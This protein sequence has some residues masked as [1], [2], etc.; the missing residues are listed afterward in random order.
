MVK[1]WLR[2]YRAKKARQIFP[3]FSTSGL[4]LGTDYAEAEDQMILMEK[5]FWKSQGQHE[6]TC[7]KRSCWGPLG[8]WYSSSSSGHD[9]HS[10]QGRP[11]Y[12][13]SHRFQGVQWYKRHHN[14]NVFMN[15]LF[16][17]PPPPS[18][19]LHPSSNVPPLLGSSKALHPLNQH[20]SKLILHWLWEV[21]NPPSVQ[22]RHNVNELEVKLQSLQ[23]MQHS[24][25]QKQGCWVT[26]WNIQQVTREEETV[27]SETVSKEGGLIDVSQ[28]NELSNDKEKLW[29]S[30]WSPRT[31]SLPFCKNDHCYTLQSQTQND[32]CHVTW[33]HCQKTWL[34][35]HSKF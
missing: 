11:G 22:N 17:Q 7:W 18:A 31:L 34:P 26:L 10:T 13:T 15:W 6:Q 30:W 5:P 19:G 23:K 35:I 27:I 33:T 29:A 1:S 16:L 25:N 20:L 24:W 8:H 3:P 4:S 21:L 2:W 12:P 9:N 28:E 14:M 32:G